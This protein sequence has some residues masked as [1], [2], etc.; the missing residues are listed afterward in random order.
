MAAEHLRHFLRAEVAI[1]I[2]PERAPG[3]RWASTQLPT[4]IDVEPLRFLPQLAGSQIELLFA[5]LS[6]PTAF[7][8]CDGN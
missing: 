3:L 2:G 4:L 7:E 1:A 8:S 5:D 6:D